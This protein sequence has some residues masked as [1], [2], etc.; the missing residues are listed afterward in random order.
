MRHSYFGKKLSRTKNQR[1]GLLVGLAREIIEHGSIKTTLAKAKAVQP[2]VEK[3][4]T[5]AKLGSDKKMVDITYRKV[6]R[7]LGDKTSA[8]KLVSDGLTRFANRG[9]GFTKIIKLGVRTGDGSEEVLFGFVDAAIVAQVI[10]PKTNKT[11]L[12]KKDEGLAKKPTTGAKTT[13]KSKTQ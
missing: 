5:K 6:F 4:I 3:L 2:M 10:E 13:K 9:S 12:V 8:K 1:R 11:Q 7:E